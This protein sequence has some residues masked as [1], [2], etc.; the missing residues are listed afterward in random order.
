ME[1]ASMYKSNFLK[2]RRLVVILLAMFLLTACSAA[3]APVFMEEASLPLAE[4]REAAGEFGNVSDDFSF[5]EYNSPSANRLV[6]KNADL[7]IVVDD[8]ALTLD[9]IARLADEMGGFV[10]SANLYHTRLESGAEVPHATITIRIPAERLDEALTSIE[11]ESNRLPLTKNISSQDVTKDYTDLQS[12]LRNLEEAEAQL[13]E[14]M[15][16]ANKTED[17]LSVYNQ[18]VQV[19]E[20]IEVTKGQIQYF[21]QSAAL[22]AISV[23]ILADEAVQPLTVG[24]WQPG[25]V[26][27]SAIQA[28]INS[29]KFIGNALIWIGLFILPVLLLLAVIFLLPLYLVARFVRR[30]RARRKKESQGISPQ[31]PPAPSE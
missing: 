1:V 12:R 11:S 28:L 22:S 3:Q 26:A 17:V 18:L 4:P 21:E 24:G 13:R 31:E 25:G 15:A 6:I 14:I 27:K 23:E 16:S 2:H 7:S 10:V 20:Q 30:R 29:I 9:H 5:D 19:R 8:P